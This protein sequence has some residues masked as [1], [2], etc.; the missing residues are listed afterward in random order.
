MG[1]HVVAEGSGDGE[2]NGLGLVGSEHWEAVERLPP[3]VPPAACSATL[4]LRRQPSAPLLLP[5]AQVAKHDNPY[6]ACKA[7]VSQAYKLWLQKETR[8]DDISAVVLKKQEG[9]V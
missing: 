7:L 8:T 6:D 5:P 4:A 2:H 9:G 1:V 3:F